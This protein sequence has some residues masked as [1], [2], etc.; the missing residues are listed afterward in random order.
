MEGHE[1]DVDILD[2]GAVQRHFERMGGALLQ[3][4][5]PLAGKVLTHFYSVSWEGAV[6]TWTLAFEREF[7]RYRGYDLRPYLPALAGV[8]VTGPAVTE[9]FLR[10]YNR[11]LADCFMDNCYGKLQD[12]CHQAGLQWHSESGGPWNRKL[13]SFRDADQLAFLGRNDMPQGEFWYPHRG[14]NRPAAM[15]AHLYG[16]RLAAAEAF[17][18]MRSH[19]A[20]YPAI[21]K[22]EADAAF[23][24]GINQLIWHTFTASPPEF[25]VPG[26]EY[27][28]GS[29]LNPNV[30]WWEYS[31]AFLTYLARCQLLLRQGQPVSDVL[32]YTGDQPYLDW[33]HGE[34]W[35]SQPSLTLGAG[36]AYDLLNT[37]VL[38]DRL[39]VK[40]GWLTLPEGTRYGLLVVD[41]EDETV[42]PAA[43]HRILE[44]AE[45]GATVVLGN[46]RPTRAPGLTNY[47]A[48]DAEVGRLAS[49]LWGPA[50]TSAIPRTVGRGKV[51]SASDMDSALR[52]AGI[53]PDFTGPGAF[54]HRRSADMDVYFLTGEGTADCL[55]R[56]RGQEPELWD[57]IRGRIRDAVRYRPTDD[58]RTLLPIHLPK[59]GSLFV[60][61]RRAAQPSRLDPAGN[62][63]GLPEIEG[64]SE[65]G[66][67]AH[68]WRPGRSQ[69][70]VSGGA[71]VTVEVDELPSPRV[72][73]GPWEV[74]FT[75]G[76][77]APESAVFERLRPWNEHPDPGIKYFSGTATYRQAFELTEGE[78][79]S[80][81]RLQLG[82]V[83]N[84]AEVRL[85]DRS[86]GV[87]WT[88]PWTVDLTGVARSG[89]NQLEIAVANLWVNRLIGD[90]GLPQEQ[91]LTKTHAR[92]QPSDQG[93]YARLRGY[94]ADD[95][96]LVSGLL[97]PVRLE[98]G[99]RVQR[100]WPPQA[101]A[102]GS[103]TPALP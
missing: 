14:I 4:A 87:V 32:C 9:R 67:T 48:C 6:P 46:R 62:A 94:L 53:L 30:T 15:A 24:D 69:W 86:L 102:S 91:R 88:D 90:A 59:N 75:R 61:F 56:V 64:R 70:R 93:P 51:I 78:A 58:G 65:S 89:V 11:T 83:A 1:N 74:R 39:S 95:P 12:L 57:P 66:F 41:L 68:V 40:D 99:A 43:L 21:L 54:A 60:V 72:L 16:R 8:T 19:W 31:G 79:K 96:L 55:F 2:A 73:A 44:L 35:H 82:D 7:A 38:L 29:H 33:G 36:Y 47:P 18:N 49:D 50:A 25:G 10:D 80:L 77:G 28:A 103:A 101:A 52:T 84:I 3:D 98:F 45:Q 92:R 5:G 20:D 22:P 63:D 85:N 100:A 97:G 26:I 81:I 71:A 17:T 37:E 34:Q 23:C 13:P 27:F 42:Q 76:W